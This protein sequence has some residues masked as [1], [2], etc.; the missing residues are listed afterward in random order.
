MENISKIDFMIL[1]ETW[2]NQN[3]DI[4]GFQTI[5]SELATPLTKN[6]CRQS[7]GINFLFKSKFKKHMTIIKNTKNFLW[8]K[9]SKTILNSNKDL[10]ICGTY[11]PPEKSNYF[12]K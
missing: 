3:I 10:Y 11:I 5:C 6:A 7:G 1:T 12:D 9:I 8:S 4:P 2:S